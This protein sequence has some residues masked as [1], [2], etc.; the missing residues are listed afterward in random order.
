M[1]DVPDWVRRKL[2]ECPVTGGGVNLWLFGMA[3]T[4]KAFVGRDEARDLLRQAVS[5][6]GRRVRDGE[7][8]R[9]IERSETIKLSSDGYEPFHSAN[10]NRCR[11]VDENGTMEAYDFWE[12]SPVRFDSDG[13]QARFVLEHLF[14][15]EETICLARRGLHDAR[16]FAMKDLPDV[17]GFSFVVPNPMK[18][19]GGTT[20]QGK[21]SQRAKNGVR[22]R[23]YVVAD[24]DQD[25][26]EQH[27]WRIEY[28]RTR[29]PLVAIT[30]SGGKGFHGWFHI[31]G[32]P[33]SAVRAFLDLVCELGGDRAAWQPHQVFRLPDGWR[34]ADPGKPGSRACRQSLLYFNP[35]PL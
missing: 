24:F 35:P 27:I 26:P 2:A 30:W 13:S 5:G 25:S 7:I 12:E 34:Y 3:G 33:D 32:K 1:S 8:D 15:P 14:R 9:A 20:D 18:P 17:E 23:R 31:E 19:G 21:P 10:E 6:C 16:L 28:L 22:F 11:M 29:A 4:L